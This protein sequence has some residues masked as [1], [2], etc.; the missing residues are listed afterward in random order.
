MSFQPLNGW[1]EKFHLL[2]GPQS[3]RAYSTELTGHICT[4]IRSLLILYFWDYACLSKFDTQFLTSKKLA[5]RI[6]G[7]ADVLRV[8]IFD[9]SCL[10]V[11]RTVLT[12]QEFTQ[13]F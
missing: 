5:A 3:L 2:A 12:S 7:A 4:I 1:K 13:I 11:A 8:K 10:I 6:L 9:Q